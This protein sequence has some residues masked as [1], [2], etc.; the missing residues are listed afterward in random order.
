ML[1]DNLRGENDGD[2]EILGLC[3]C[4]MLGRGSLVKPWLPQELKEQ[5]TID[6]SA[7]ER[8]EMLKRFW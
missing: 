6:I 2:K 1:E 5:R 4:A 8:L 7:T 3:S